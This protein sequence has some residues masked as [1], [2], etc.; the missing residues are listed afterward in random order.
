MKKKTQKQRRGQNGPDVKKQNPSDPKQKANTS[1]STS[2]SNN[3][4]AAK[5]NLRRSE[6]RAKYITNPIMFDPANY[7]H[8]ASEGV[9]DVF[10]EMQQAYCAHMSFEYPICEI[11]IHG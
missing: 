10:G 7:G 11:G 2:S 3:E 1:S 8:H 9:D 4:Q 6:R 5:L